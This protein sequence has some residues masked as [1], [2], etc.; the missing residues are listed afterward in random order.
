[1]C[2]HC[3]IVKDLG[4]LGVYLGGSCRDCPKTKEPLI[5]DSFW[6][7]MHH[8]FTSD[9]LRV[10]MSRSCSI[11]PLVSCMSLLGLFHGLS[12]ATFNLDLS[13]RRYF[14]SVET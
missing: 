1:M 5:G 7:F 10:T 8:S 2:F 9:L 4:T 13:H 14:L 11:I 3:F 12:W 6:S